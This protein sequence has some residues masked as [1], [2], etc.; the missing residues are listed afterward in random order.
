M[1]EPKSTKTFASFSGGKD[2]LAMIVRMAEMKE[3]IDAVI[4]ANTGWDFPEM[5]A[6]VEQAERSLPFDFVIVDL[7][8]RFDHWFYEYKTCRGRNEGKRQGFPGRMM[9]W[10]NRDKGRAIDR[11]MKAQGGGIN[12]IGM[13]ADERHRAERPEIHREGRIV[14]RFPLIEWGWTEQMCLDYCYSNGY[15]F[16]GYYDNF[17]RGGC[18]C[19]PQ[20]PLSSLRTLY[21]FYP[22]LWARLREMQANSHIAFRSNG[23]TVYDLEKRFAWTEK[24][25]E[26]TWADGHIPRG[27]VE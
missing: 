3:R 14:R 12:L 9:L 16:G 26:L 20:Q 5:L 11:Y 7:K 4:F 27:E 24:I 19:C 10:C 2:S 17:K 15:D 13:A 22:E 6:T 1:A 8:A 21:Q 23:D 25:D 18:F